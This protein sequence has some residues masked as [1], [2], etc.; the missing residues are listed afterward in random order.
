MLPS[1]AVT[2]LPSVALIGKL[3][4]ENFLFMRHM[5]VVSANGDVNN[6][7]LWSLKSNSILH[8][9]SCYLKVTLH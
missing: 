3:E 9:P 5:C 7:Q 4:F 6:L 2:G 8:L 1:S